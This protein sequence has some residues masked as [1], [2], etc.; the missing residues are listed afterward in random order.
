M[1][2]GEHKTYKPRA[3]GEDR[4]QRAGALKIPASMGDVEI[5][6]RGDE[7]PLVKQGYLSHFSPMH[8]IEAAPSVE[9]YARVLALA[10]MR[11][12]SSPDDN[13]EEDEDGQLALF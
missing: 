9:E 12:K 7:Y 2:Y 3:C 11:V 5:P 6:N 13:E 8:E 4:P 10:L 1:W